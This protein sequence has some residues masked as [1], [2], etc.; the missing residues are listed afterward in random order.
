MEELGHKSLNRIRVRLICDW[1]AFVHTGLWQPN[2]NHRSTQQLSSYTILYKDPESCPLNQLLNRTTLETLLNISVISNINSINQSQAF[3]D[4]FPLQAPDFPCGS[5]A[6]FCCSRYPNSWQYPAKGIKSLP[7][8]DAVPN[9]LVGSISW[10]RCWCR[11]T[12]ILLAS[13][14]RCWCRWTTILLATWGR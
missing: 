3:Q 8:Y 4:D 5:P 6:P 9:C 14:Q 2:L 1:T 7:A 13:G 12:A 11:W 10:Q